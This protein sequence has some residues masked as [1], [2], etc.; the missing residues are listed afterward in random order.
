M[1][2]HRDEHPGC[3]VMW[4]WLRWCSRY[5]YA[6]QLVAYALEDSKTM[7]PKRLE[8]Q[9]R[10]CRHYHSVTKYRSGAR[11]SYISHKEK[12]SD[13]DETEDSVRMMGDLIPVGDSFYQGRSFR[14]QVDHLH[15][16]SQQIKAVN[17]LYAYGM[18]DRSTGVIVLD[19]LK[20]LR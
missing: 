9:F 2:D 5:R 13:Y 15:F 6:S 14:E 17:V 19:N 20:K 1:R 12:W 7:D 16:Q 3:R 8:S 10:N 4:P 18:F 11:S